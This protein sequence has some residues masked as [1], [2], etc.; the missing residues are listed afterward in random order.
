MADVSP[1]LL[2]GGHP[3]GAPTGSASPNG[4]VKKTTGSS[5]N[6]GEALFIHKAPRVRSGKR[7]SQQ[8]SSQPRGEVEQPLHQEED[9]TIVIDLTE[10]RCN[11]TR[12]TNWGP[13]EALSEEN[14]LIARMLNGETAPEEELCGDKR[15]APASSLFPPLAQSIATKEVEGERLQEEEESDE[16]DDPNL[17]VSLPTEKY[18][19]PISEED[20]VQQQLGSFSINQH[21]QHKNEGGERSSRSRKRPS[22]TA[23]AA[24]STAAATAAT[25]AAAPLSIFDGEALSSIRFLPGSNGGYQSL[26]RRHQ[27]G[28]E[29]A[30]SPS[31]GHGGGTRRRRTSVRARKSRSSDFLD[32]LDVSASSSDHRKRLSTPLKMSKIERGLYLGNMEAATDVLLL[33]SHHITH[34]ITLDTVP[35]PRKISSFLPRV[36]FLHLH[37]TDLVDEDILSHV[38]PAI[39]FI[40][41]GLSNENGGVLVH[42][43][44]GKS[45]S[46]AIVLAYVMRKYKYTLEKALRKVRARRS[47]ICPHQGFLAQLKLFESMEFTLDTSNVQF[48]MFRVSL[49][50]ER[51]RKAKVLFRDSLDYILDDDPGEVPGGSAKCSQVYKCK[52]CRRTLATSHNLSPHESGETPRWTEPKWSLPAEEVLEG[53]SDLGLR[54]C[55]RSVFINPVAW[56][57]TEIKQSLGGALYCPNCQTRVGDF[58][59]VAGT[60][61]GGGSGGKAG[62]GAAISP[63]FQLLVTE[64]IFKTKNRFLQSSGREP[65]VV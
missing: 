59:W 50:A 64:I 49:A 40:E 30:N 42:C 39:E 54:L 24:N 10:E 43:F 57:R 61:C 32:R 11:L 14:F 5:S 19:D 44:R 3:N 60:S 2:V 55:T 41:E 62:C 35:L 12:S 17:S 28:G 56:M 25:A 53:A 46:A 9:Q 52:S 6:G 18:V 37:V 4:D 38:D 23:A 58:S 16:E 63:S 21:Q 51:M 29:T 20:L 33:E 27:R 15:I 34:I 8:N 7:K 36:N 65:V 22:V 45:R 13:E 31:G 26:D 1:L 48:K 47:C